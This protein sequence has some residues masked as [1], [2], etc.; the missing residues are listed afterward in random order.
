MA[1]S[2]IKLR[3][4]FISGQTLTP[5]KSSIFFPIF[6]GGRS[7]TVLENPWS[8]NLTKEAATTIRKKPSNF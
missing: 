2:L 8:F 4:M 3:S 1:I 7:I 6:G 5:M